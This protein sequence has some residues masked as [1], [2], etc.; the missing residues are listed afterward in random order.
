[1]GFAHETVQ[2]SLL[3]AVL[4]FLRARFQ[5]GDAGQG[6]CPAAAED[7]VVVQCM[8]FEMGVSW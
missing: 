4:C 1:M 2:G 3:P 6:I 8:V 5:S 7:T